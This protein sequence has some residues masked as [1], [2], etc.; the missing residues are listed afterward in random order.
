V[1]GALGVGGQ[2]RTWG[3]LNSATGTL[4]SG[5][6]IHSPTWDAAYV[7]W[8]IGAAFWVL[9]GF[10]HL[11]D[12]AAVS[13]IAAPI[14]GRYNPLCCGGFTFTSIEMSGLITI[15]IGTLCFTGGSTA[16]NLWWNRASITCLAGFMVWSIASIGYTGASLY[17][18]MMTML[19]PEATPLH[20]TNAVASFTSS[21]YDTV[22]MCLYDIGF[23]LLIV[24]DPQGSAFTG[25]LLILVASVY[26]LL[27]SM[28]SG[29]GSSVRQSGWGL[30]AR[31]YVVT[32]LPA[33]TVGAMAPQPAGAS[34]REM[35]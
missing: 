2:Q 12:N 28:S 23:I 13:A 25:S 17:Y 3:T 24:L 10:F 11:C 1:G 18:A 34:T 7:L 29:P 8:I 15:L 5:A 30:M 14:A 32:A 20:R 31:P 16:N 35:Y 27:G 21:L 33:G 6:V 9:G 26:K 22:A 19:L 4:S